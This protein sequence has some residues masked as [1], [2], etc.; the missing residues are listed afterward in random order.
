M[1][2]GA[3]FQVQGAISKVMIDEI[4]QRRLHEFLDNLQQRINR[5]GDKIFETFF[6]LEPLSQPVG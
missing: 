1:K 6:T 4:L 2:L 5:V 3:N